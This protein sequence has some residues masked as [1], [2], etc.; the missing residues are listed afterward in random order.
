METFCQ[1]AF[2]SGFTRRFYV[3]PLAFCC[4]LKWLCFEN[5]IE[6]LAFFNPN[7]TL[8]NKPVCYC[9]RPPLCQ[10]VHWVWIMK[11]HSL[12][13]SWE[14]KPVFRKEALRGHI[15][16][17]QPAATPC[18]QM[19]A[20]SLWFWEK[21]NKKWKKSCHQLLWSY[22]RSVIFLL[23]IL[24]NIYSIGNLIVWLYIKYFS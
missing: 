12:A 20:E 4:T 9:C 3:C 2:F 15:T 10:E 23:V 5:R 19:W 13:A 17:R 21:L 6:N 24:H 16:A 1:R 7:Y 22:I 18:H 8:K 14:D 11:T